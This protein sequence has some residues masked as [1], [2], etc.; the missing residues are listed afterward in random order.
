MFES[1]HTNLPRNIV[2]LVCC[3]QENSLDDNSIIDICLRM[4][5]HKER[6]ERMILFLSIGN[7]TAGEIV[8]YADS[9]A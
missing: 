3:L 4:Y 1:G 8:S 6:T 9:L 5:G 7:R 2:D